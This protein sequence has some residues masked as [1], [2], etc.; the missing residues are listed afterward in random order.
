M[1]KLEG[2]ATDEDVRSLSVDSVVGVAEFDAGV[3][4]GNGVV[5]G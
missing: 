1:N 5:E 2:E 3:G 4:E